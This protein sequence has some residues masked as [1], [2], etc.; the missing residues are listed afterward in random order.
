MARS[1]TRKQDAADEPVR[2]NRTEA[3]SRSSAVAA[4]AFARAGFSDPTLIL[5]WIDIVG[6]DIARFAEPLRLTDG[7][8]GGT[9]TLRAEP[10][11]SVF[12]QHQTRALCERINAFL[13]RPAI[14]KLRFVNGTVAA[15]SEP[16]RRPKPPAQPP[17]GDPATNFA[18]PDQLKAAL[19]NLARA[20]Q[21][22][23]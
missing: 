17:Q 23:G 16:H 5:R 21:I 15:P 6:P 2:R 18:G 14:A 3:I 7:P 22:R 1:E 10:A 19:L 13:G 11:A 8:S 20:R 4:T 12:L 9:L